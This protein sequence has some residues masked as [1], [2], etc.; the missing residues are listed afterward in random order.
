MITRRA[1]LLMLSALAAPGPVAAQAEAGNAMLP[2][3]LSAVS[4]LPLRTPQGALTTIGAHLLSAPT[5]IA[6]WATWCSP[7]MMEGRELARLRT[8]VPPER[9]NIIGVNLD[10]AEVRE[11]S[12]LARFMQRA[13]MNYLQLWGNVTLYRAFN[14]P[15]EGA[16]VA[17][18]RLYVFDASGAPSAAFGRYDG[19]ASLAE[20]AAA[21]DR[22]LS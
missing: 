15:G 9:L 13:Q 8:R 12:R 7:C 19:A 14:N 1:T 4:D 18:P 5:V 2:P 10:R 3:P 6:F 21:V 11:S 22:V 16:S 17:L 20:I